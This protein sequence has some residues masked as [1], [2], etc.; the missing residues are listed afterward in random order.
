[1][2]LWYSCNSQTNSINYSPTSL[3]HSPSVPDISLWQGIHFLLSLSVS[4]IEIVTTRP[5]PFSHRTETTKTGVGKHPG[6][7]LQQTVFQTLMVA[8]IVW[9]WLIAPA[10]V[11]K[12]PWSDRINSLL[13]LQNYIYI[14][15]ERE[16]ENY[17]YTYIYICISIYIY[18]YIFFIENLIMIYILPFTL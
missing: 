12:A 18:I 14:Y 17:G 13:P 9:R 1:M 8:A 16:I 11:R 15:R 4:D 3:A 6:G 2:R 5:P 10:G 7:E